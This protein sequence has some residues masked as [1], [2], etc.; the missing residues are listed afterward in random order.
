MV[1]N[2]LSARLSLNVLHEVHYF[3]RGPFLAQILI[4]WLTIFDFGTKTWKCAEIK[5]KYELIPFCLFTML[6]SWEAAAIV[7]FT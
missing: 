3:L 7:R 6:S 4:Q 5:R 2:Y 1:R